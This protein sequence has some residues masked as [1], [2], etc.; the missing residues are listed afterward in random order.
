[1][2][3]GII[4]STVLTMSMRLYLMAHGGYPGQGENIEAINKRMIEVNTEQERED[5]VNPSFG[6]IAKEAMRGFG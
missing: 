2:G 4:G 1:M 6:K 3:L 5:I